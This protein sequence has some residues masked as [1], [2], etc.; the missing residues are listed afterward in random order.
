[1]IMKG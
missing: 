1:V